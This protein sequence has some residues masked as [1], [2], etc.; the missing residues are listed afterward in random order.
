MLPVGEEIVQDLSRRTQLCSVPV[1]MC[2]MQKGRAWGISLDVP[3]TL[4]P[5]LFL[6]FTCILEFITEV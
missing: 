4:A 2:P 6:L 1:I 3:S 5:C